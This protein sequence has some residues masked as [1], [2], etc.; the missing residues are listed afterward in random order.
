M[1][2]PINGA[3]RGPNTSAW[4]SALAGVEGDGHK[5]N[6]ILL[7]WTGEQNGKSLRME[8]QRH[9]GRILPG[10]CCG[11]ALPPCTSGASFVSGSSTSHSESDQV[12]FRKWSESYPHRAN[13]VLFYHAIKLRL[14]CGRRDASSPAAQKMMEHQTL[15]RK[16]SGAVLFRLHY[17]FNLVFNTDKP[18]IH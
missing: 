12:G 4:T 1:S 13:P 7:R 15:S 17:I 18:V 10:F 6:S 11:R 8:L 2:A 16:R 5:T 14:R 3:A 9:C